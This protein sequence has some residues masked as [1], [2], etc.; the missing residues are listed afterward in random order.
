MLVLSGVGTP[1][2]CWCR[3]KGAAVWFSLLLFCCLGGGALGHVFVEGYRILLGLVKRDTFP[4]LTHQPFFLTQASLK[5]V[6]A[7]SGIP[8]W[9]IRKT[10][11]SH[12]GVSS[13]AILAVGPKGEDPRFPF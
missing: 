9:A 1:F 12:A 3:L 2:C 10:T 11:L 8:K 4:L 6:A 5:Q 7:L 13:L